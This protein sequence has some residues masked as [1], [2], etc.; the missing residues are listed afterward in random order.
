[1]YT[2]WFASFARA[3]ISNTNK[4]RGQTWGQTLNNIETFNSGH[5][6]QKNPPQR[7]QEIQIA[8][9]MVMPVLF[10]LTFS[11]MY[12]SSGQGIKRIYGRN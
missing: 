6:Q 9:I 10:N 3:S 2:I 11:I 4:F 5:K 12:N 1:M 7:R 8:C